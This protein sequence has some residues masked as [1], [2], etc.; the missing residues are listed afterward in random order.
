MILY[1]AQAT[2]P[3]LL[4]ALNKISTTQAKETIN[5]TNKYNDLL[6]FVPTHPNTVIQY[7]ESDLILHVDS[8]VVYL[9]LPKLKIRIVA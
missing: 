3:T 1:Y 5:T 4:P 7:N 8:H 2:D 6:E 9:V